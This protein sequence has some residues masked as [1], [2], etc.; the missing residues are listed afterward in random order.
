MS[1][2]LSALPLLV[3]VAGGSLVVVSA[4]GASSTGVEGSNRPLLLTGSVAGGGAEIASMG[5][6]GVTI[7]FIDRGRFFVGV[8]LR[9]GSSH[10]LRVINVNTAE[11]ANSLVRQVGTRLAPVTPC[12]GRMFCSFLPSGADAV[13]LRPVTLAP[14]AQVGV[15]LN[16]RLGS[17]SDVP[18][19]SLAT[20]RVLDVRYEDSQG[21][22]RRQTFPI[23]GASLFLRKPAGVECVRRPYSH[24]G[25]VGSF[26]TSPGHKGRCLEATATRAPRP[27]P[28]G[29]SSGADSL[30]TGAESSSGSRSPSLTS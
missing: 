3:A 22:R 6:S 25:L 23:G 10:T 19:T 13:R 14:G 24:I 17:C 21:A 5:P 27:P 4:A 16:Y 20:A 7:R 11:P 8:L 2:T 26:R 15:Q 9:N 12:K 29:C 18:L 1:R 30:R 28:E